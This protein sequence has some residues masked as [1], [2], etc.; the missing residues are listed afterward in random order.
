MPYLDSALVIAKQTDNPALLETIYYEIGVTLLLGYKLEASLDS[1]NKGLH[2]S[3]LNDYRKRGDILYR[4]AS[5]LFQMDRYSEALEVISEIE[6]DPTGTNKNALIKSIAM[7][8]QIYYYLDLLDL[9]YSTLMRTKELSGEELHRKAAI[10]LGSVLMDLKRYEEAIK[11]YETAWKGYE[12]E[13]SNVL[14]KSFI[15]YRMGRLYSFVGNRD[16]SR[17]LYER[18]L[19]Y[20]NMGN[21]VNNAYY[22]M[23]IYIYMIKTE[24]DFGYLKNAVDY[25]KLFENENLDNPE[26]N[27]QYLRLW[28]EIYKKKA[29]ADSALYY[30]RRT[31]K[32]EEERRGGLNVESFRVGYMGLKAYIYRDMASLFLKKYKQDTTQKALVD[33]AFHYLSSVQN[34]AAEDF[35]KQRKSGLV[36]TSKDSIYIEAR[37]KVEHLQKRLRSVFDRQERSK[38]LEKLEY[39]RYDLLDSR[40]HLVDSVTLSQKQ[41]LRSTDE[42][43]G[44]LRKLD[45]NAVVYFLHNDESHAFLLTP[46][47]EEL[48][49]LPAHPD[50]I[51][52]H[53]ELLMKPFAEIP[54]SANIPFNASSAHFLYRAL[55][56]PVEKFF[57]RKTIILIPDGSL[58]S[59]SFSMLL[60]EQP[61]RDYFYPGESDIPDSSFLVMDYDM[62]YAPGTNWYQNLSI[63][64]SRFNPHNVAAFGAVESIPGVQTSQSRFA[65]FGLWAPLLYARKELD[66]LKS[67]LP[68]IKIFSDE[69]ATPT[70]F[71]SQLKQADVVHLA[72]H[73]FADT[74][75]DAF[76]GLV[77]S[78]EE[79]N[80]GLVMGYEM[81]RRIVSSKL[82]TLS[83][84]ETGRGQIVSG[85]GVLGMPRLFLRSGA[86]TIVMTLWRIDDRFTADFMPQFYDA[87]LTQKLAAGPALSETQRRVLKGTKQQYKHPVYW[88]AF[89]V[90]GNAHLQAEPES[91][92]N[93]LLVFAAIIVFLFSAYYLTKRAAQRHSS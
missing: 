85:E 20:V 62:S 8:G 82:I 83:A 93:Y 24:L 92:Q 59:L 66:Q 60:K 88:A 89:N 42:M 3:A 79:D 87:L 21:K 61:R 58:Q 7:K 69:A 67:L 43:R 14:V 10:T 81:D 53:V 56:F 63:A 90:Y 75:Y 54:E 48:I 6:N 50:T 32:I 31:A 44:A 57:S 55:V 5:V 46:E 28:A 76:S 40:M 17:E 74:T 12:K 47:K 30:L 33:S 35:I 2:Y 26:V 86:Q 36:E 37:Q 52:K 23:N 77:L 34:R 29:E 78:A 72:S 70:Q 1:L 27:S 18:A 22:R 51:S 84:C 38:L 11:S 80:D 19:E 39:A 25:M 91:K 65:S 73:A 41:I 49:S 16:K 4:I 68:D 9:A 71:F 15:L 64:E 13:T 45:A